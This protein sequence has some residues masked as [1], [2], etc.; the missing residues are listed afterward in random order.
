MVFNGG[1]CKLLKELDV[2]LFWYCGAALQCMI[3]LRK[4]TPR[5]KGQGDLSK[6]RKPVMEQELE[7]LQQLVTKD[8]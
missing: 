1:R 4:E 2:T 6:Q 7:I 3:K 8:K 5:K